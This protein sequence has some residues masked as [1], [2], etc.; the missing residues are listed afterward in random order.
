MNNA[1]PER[2]RPAEEVS[3]L[4]ERVIF[5]NE[6]TGFC[7]LRVKIKGQREEVT[8]VGSLPAVTAGE[9]LVAEGW[10]I[11]D[12]EHGL[13]FKATAMKTVPPTTAEGISFSG[14]PRKICQEKTVKITRFQL[15]QKIR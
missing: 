10:W 13:Q 5:F 1:I 12:K 6:E 3:G 7:V 15:S 14:F 9:W 8:V 4:L 11:R 2:Q